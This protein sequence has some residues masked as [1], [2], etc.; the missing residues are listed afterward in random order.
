[1][2]SL[3]VLFFAF[4]VLTICNISVFTQENNEQFGWDLTYSSLLKTNNIGSK[5]FIR[6]WLAKDYQAP[7]KKWI[8]EW[9][10]E[11]IISSILIEYASFAHPGEHT[12]VW[13]FRTKDRAYYWQDIE[14]VK[15]SDIKKELKL[16]VYDEMLNQA[17][18]WKQAKPNQPKRP[19]SI[20]GYLGF[21]DLFDKN[22]PRQMLLSEEDFLICKTKKCKGVKAGR[23]TLALETLFLREGHKDYR[24]KSKAELV[25]LTPAQRV[26][27]YLKEITYHRRGCI[28]NY[29]NGFDQRDVI[30]FYIAK[31]GVKTLPA[32]AEVA[33]RYYPKQEIDDYLGF[34]ASNAFDLARMIDTN[35]IRIRATK[36]GLSVIKAFEDVLN[37]MKEAGYDDQKSKWNTR[38]LANLDTL[39]ILQGGKLSFTDRDIQ[40]TWLTELNI[41]ISD[42]EMIKFSNYLTS[43]DPTYPRR[44]KIDPPIF[45]KNYKELYEAYLK[46][47]AKTV[48]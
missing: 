28:S 1:M 17:S 27:E 2:K 38:Y 43:L 15:F 24:H 47:K 29:T 48:R 42:D 22:E 20:P 12:T 16:E 19:Q 33:N 21:L 45:C 37:R 10:G 41:R 40:L 34:D 9:K 5:A 31:D 13:L 11:P 18:S 39:R 46:F 44:C 35:L 4:I 8:S 3:L 6:K 26:D 30:A 23:L 7:A 36:E 32:L 14:N 25:A